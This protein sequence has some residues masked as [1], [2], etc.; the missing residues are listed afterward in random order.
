M[1]GGCDPTRPLPCISAYSLGYMGKEW[2]SHEPSG[3]SGLVGAVSVLWAELLDPSFCLCFP[4]KISSERQGLCLLLWLLSRVG[5]M[6]QEQL[7]RY[8][9]IFQAKTPG[10]Q[11]SGS[12]GGLVSELGCGAHV[13]G[14]AQVFHLCLQLGFSLGTGPR[15]PHQRDPGSQTA[16][17]DPRGPE[18]SLTHAVARTMFSPVFKNKLWASLCIPS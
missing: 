12:L 11:N 16:V 14:R 8:V 2:G 4:W 15:L 3:P 5:K 18:P 9:T 10:R 7:C 13:D 1:E 6:A 17:W